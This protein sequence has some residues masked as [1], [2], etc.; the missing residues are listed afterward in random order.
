MSDVVSASMV[1]VVVRLGAQAEERKKK[2]L[3]AF[4]AAARHGTARRGET[5]V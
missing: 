3:L 5:R 1:V 4:D 2:E